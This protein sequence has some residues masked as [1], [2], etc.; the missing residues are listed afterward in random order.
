MSPSAANRQ[1]MLTRGLPGVKE[2]IEDP[3]GPGI[4]VGC[5]T[6]S[7]WKCEVCGY[8]HR[9]EAP[10]ATCPVCGASAEAFVPL[11]AVVEPPAGKAAFWRCTVCGYVHRGDVPLER[12]PVCGATREMF[13]PYDAAAAA[14][15]ASSVRRLVIVGAGIAGLTAAEHARALS[16]DVDI[17]LLSKEPGPPYYRLNLTRYLAGEVADEDLR[18]HGERWFTEQRIGLVTGEAAEIDRAGRRVVLHDGKALSYDRLVL[19][20][21]A[22]PFIPPLPG[23]TREGVSTLRTREDA[24]RLLERARPGARCVC[25]GGGLLGLETA[26]ALAR[27][28]ARVTL[29]EGFG[30]LLPRQLAEPA[31]KLLARVVEARGLAVRCGVK[32]EEL[33]GDESVGAVRLAGGESLPAELV[34]IAAGV[35]PNSHLARRCGLKVNTGVLVD[36][37]MATS[38]PDVYACGDVSEHRGVCYGIWPAAFV[39]GGVAGAAALGGEAAFAGIPPSNRLKVLD[40]DLFS[41]GRFQP[42]DAGDEVLE[43]EAGGAYHRL[44]LR[45]G[46]L[47]GANL[48]G[49]TAAAN[50]VREAI[51]ARAQTSQLPA[52]AAA[53]PWAAARL[54]GA[55]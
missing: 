9:G 20:N 5:G 43:R 54:R 49:D 52:L 28:G 51:E 1:L 8:V 27:R 10:P 38:D 14:R 34:V 46:G 3:A 42:Q 41:I 13:E 24:R 47:V 19:A 15:V 39:Q 21:G 23:A 36:D 44:L 26:G 12:C 6:M 40:V 33:G 2:A 37:R 4:A 35:R 45:D 55:P 53:F 17:V 32:V 30:W 50:V 29:L 22:H 18:V 11:T 16:A 7:T 48:F 25:I 31:G